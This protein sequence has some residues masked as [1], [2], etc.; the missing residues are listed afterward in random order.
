[1]GET[2]LIKNKLDLIGNTP[3]VYL[4]YYSKKYNCNI[5]AKLE[6]Y[7]LTYSSKDRMV[8]NIIINTINNNK[9]NKS[10]TI[11]EV[12]SGNTAISLACICKIFKTFYQ[13][14]VY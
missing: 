14:N 10:T 9:I 4:S 1:M 7:N 11:I 5:Y 3:L 2:M 13:L 12:S 6:K 8:K